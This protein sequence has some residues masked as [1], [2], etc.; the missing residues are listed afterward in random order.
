MFLLRMISVPSQVVEA[1]IQP[2]DTDS[3]KK[4]LCGNI[5]LILILGH[6]FPSNRKV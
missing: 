1:W 5:F 6:Y 4:L 3:F 2:K